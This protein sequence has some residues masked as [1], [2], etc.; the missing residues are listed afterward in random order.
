MHAQEPVLQTIVS[1]A[2]TQHSRHRMLLGC[3]FAL[4]TSTALAHPG[5]THLDGAPGDMHLHALLPQSPWSVLLLVVLAVAGVL[6]LRARRQG[7]R[8]KAAHARVAPDH[9]GQVQRERSSLKQDK[10][11]L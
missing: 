7:A 8:R 2:A 5:H 6:W 1:N 3:F 10:D 4:L 9:S 11:G